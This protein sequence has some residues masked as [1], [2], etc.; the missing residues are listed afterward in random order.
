MV[1]MVLLLIVAIPLALYRAAGNITGEPG[2]IGL[3]GLVGPSGEPGPRGFP[4]PGG[5]HG[6]P[7]RDGHPGADGADG[8]PGSPGEAGSD[9]APGPQGEPGPAGAPGPQGEKGDPGRG[10]ASTECTPDGWIVHYDDGTQENAGPCQPPPA[11]LSE[12]FA[13]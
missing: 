7:G 2:P 13:P 11:S 6:D 3:P 9:G 12:R 8:E 5:P 10:I 4:G 1:V